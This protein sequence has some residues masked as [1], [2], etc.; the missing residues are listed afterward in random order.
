MEPEETPQPENS[1]A[2]S[3]EQ[4]TVQ[5]VDTEKVER[6]WT[7][8]THLSGLLMLVS[9]PGFLGPLVIWLLKKEEFPK[10]DEAGK[11]ALNFQLTMLLVQLIS[12]PLCFVF[13]G[14]ITMFAAIILAIIFPIIAGIE[15]NKGNS[16]VYP[17]TL[18]MIK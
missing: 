5:P 11:E 9:I 13:V 17:L 4:A 3:P 14:F 1:P 18:R 2:V 12:I 6:D 10:V 7:M 15:A 16:Y 8:Y